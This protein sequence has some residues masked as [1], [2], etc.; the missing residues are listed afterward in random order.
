MKTVSFDFER[1]GS[2]EDFYKIA[3]NELRLPDYFG[4]N[5]DALWDCLTGD[6]EL[7]VQ[8]RFINLSMNQLEQFDKLIGLFEDASVE[9]NGS[10]VFEY[11]L[12]QDSLEYF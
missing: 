11:Y 1:I 9:L 5:L 7:P 2:M 6:L 3:K 4:E 8:V 10:L 12:K